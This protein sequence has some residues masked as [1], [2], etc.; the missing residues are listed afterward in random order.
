MC[1]LTSCLLVSR[2]NLVAGPILA[3]S[4]VDKDGRY[5][6]DNR[7]DDQEEQC[8]THGKTYSV[9]SATTRRRFRGRRGQS[10]LGRR[11]RS[12]LGCRW[13]ALCW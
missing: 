13:T 1:T 6:H 4:S 2:E 11:G 9:M 5:H 8:E 10:G 3:V 12:G 7:N